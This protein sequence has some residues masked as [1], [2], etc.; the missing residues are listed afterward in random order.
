MHLKKYKMS[1]KLSSHG[2]LPELKVLEENFIVKV[3][4][5]PG[6]QAQTY[7]PSTSETKAACCE[8]PAW[9]HTG[10]LSQQIHIKRMHYGM[11]P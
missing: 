7:P 4:E 2:K 1:E 3:V 5:E 6:I 8:I 10:T 11:T 9:L